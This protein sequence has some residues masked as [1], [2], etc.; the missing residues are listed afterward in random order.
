MCPVIGEYAANRISG[1]EGPPALVKAF[2]IPEK[3]YP[4]PAPATRPDSTRRGVRPP[5]GE[6]E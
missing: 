3:E 5:P 6:F 4:P 2:K 1:V